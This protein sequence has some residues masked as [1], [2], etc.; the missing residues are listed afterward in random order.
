VATFVLVHGAWHGGWC[1]DKLVPLLEREGHRV[2]AVD[3]PGHGDD[4]TPASEMTLDANAQRVVEH[5]ERAGEPVILVGHSM[6]GMVVTQAAELAPDKVAR[7]VY[8]AAFLPANGQSLLDLAAGDD[9]DFVQQ[10]LI[11]D[12]ANGTAL[13]ADEAVRQ[14]FYAECSDEDVARAKSNLVPESLAAM[15]APVQTTAEGWGSVPR[16]YIECTRDGAIDIERQRRMQA[17]LPCVEVL[18]IDTDHSPFLSR[19]EELAA[20]L[21]SL[22]A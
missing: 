1:W 13:V 15:A 8:L 17:A 14:A 7:L 20:H 11:V 22:A 9:P 18:S 19:P 2:V 12:E 4:R 16:V 10:N 21:L 5:L 3:L 6:G